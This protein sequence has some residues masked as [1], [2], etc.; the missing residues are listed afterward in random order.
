M[1]ISMVYLLIAQ[2]FCSLAL[3]QTEATTDTTSAANTSAISEADTTV[4]K[5]PEYTLVDVDDMVGGAAHRFGV[6]LFFIGGYSDKQFR[7]DN[8]SFDIFDSYV[9]FSYLLSNDIRVSARPAFGYST[10]GVNIY[11]DEVTN[12]IRIRD[13]SFAASVRNIFSDYIDPAL[14]LKFK[15]RLYLPTSDASK[16]TGMIARLRL[17]TRLLYYLN[18]YTWMEFYVKPSYFFQRNTVA[19]S[20][21]N[22]KRPPV[23]QTTALADSEHGVEL[24]YNLSRT[25]S[26][27]PAVGFT[28][29]WT[30]TS[31]VNTAREKIQFRQTSLLYGMGLEVRPTRT[32]SF[33]LGVRT[34]KDLIVADKSEETSYSLLWN[35][36]LF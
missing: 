11:G 21:A 1:K 32:I 27:Q 12:K 4:E 24:H 9:A 15:P 20:Y 31:D 23:L 28:E 29:F 8:P 34:E 16:D 14:E 35:S 25:F 36:I 13:F 5:T 30:N 2:M 18:R 3:A 10:E 33:I 6:A 7:R 22:P 26:L 19:L 17:E